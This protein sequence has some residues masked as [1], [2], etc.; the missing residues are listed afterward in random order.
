MLEKLTYLSEQFAQALDLVAQ[1]PGGA[2]VD[3][4]AAAGAVGAEAHLAIAGA[5]FDGDFEHMRDEADFAA[6]AFVEAVFDVVGDLQRRDAADD[7]VGEDPRG[8]Q[9]GRGVVVVP[10]G[11]EADFPQ[12]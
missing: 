6:V 4:E 2:D 7:A 3:A 8:R 5:A 1:C 10:V 11:V 9:V 12:N